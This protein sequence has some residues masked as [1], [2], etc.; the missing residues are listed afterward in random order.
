MTFEWD[1]N[2]R[3]ANL[4]KHRID[5]FDV[6]TV[7]CDPCRLEKI[8]NRKDYGEVRTNTIGK[9]ED[10]IIVLVVHTDRNRKIRIISARQ[11]KRKERDLYYGNSKLYK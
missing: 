6:I 10:E 5:F 1:E 9:L 3:L 2:K 7:F 11:A 8:D 4:A